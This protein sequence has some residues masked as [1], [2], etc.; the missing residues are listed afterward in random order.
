[1]AICAAALIQAMTLGLAYA[2]WGRHLTDLVATPF[3]PVALCEANDIDACTQAVQGFAAAQ[4]VGYLLYA[5][6][7]YTGIAFFITRVIL[8]NR[9]ASPRQVLPF[10]A[11][12]LCGPLLVTWAVGLSGAGYAIFHFA[13]LL[14]G[15]ASGLFWRRGRFLPEAH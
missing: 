14:A 1:M 3:L 8:G 4:I 2:E 5:G 10:I 15:V 7:L 11:V 12:G 13:A 6:V 9:L